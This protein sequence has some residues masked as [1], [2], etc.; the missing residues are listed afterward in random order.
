MFGPGPS[1]I[2]RVF[3]L[4]FTAFLA[5][6]CIAQTG[7]T[8]PATGGPS[9]FPNVDAGDRL[10]TLTPYAQITGVYDLTN[11]LTTTNQDGQLTKYDSTRIM[12]TGGL[13]GF[14]AWETSMLGMSFRGSF[15]H[16][17]KSN[18]P[19]SNSEFLSLG[20]QHAIS[21]HVTV[22]LTEIG[23]SSNLALSTAAFGL[24]GSSVLP[25][26]D[27]VD[28]ATSSLPINDLFDGRVYFSSTGSAVSYQRT[29][30]LSFFAGGGGFFVRRHETGAPGV[31]GATA[32]GGTMYQ[33]SRRQALSLEY[34][35]VR[36]DYT[37]RFGNADSQ[38][39]GLGYRATL[40]PHW[41]FQ[42]MAGAY[43]IRRLQ[44]TQV[45]LDPLV[46][47]LLGQ[48]TS[49]Q[50]QEGKSYL[51]AGNARLDGKF[52]HSTVTLS[53][54]RTSSA[55]NNVF[56]ASRLDLASGSYT[57]SLQK[58]CSLMLATAYTRLSSLGGDY[59][60]LEQIAAISSLS[61]RVANPI[62]FTASFSKRRMLV[63]TGNSRPDST[64]AMIG[65]GF[66][67]NGVPLW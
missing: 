7:H 43:R 26:L 62:Y 30:R 38:M 49:S 12:A 57:Y 13:D 8:D 4:C 6:H 40:S 61:Y 11:T 50:V 45:A 58:R 44:T 20:F 28:Q 23:G 35:F 55:G 21:R 54:R 16:R 47:A 66:S 60:P 42:A 25:G 17:L 51:G 34:T 1:T 32:H 63:N 53:Y 52:R 19:D 65:V 48:R 46:A 5:S 36:Y 18:V 56:L 41:E 67:P 15:Q 27:S 9:L 33:V 39:A 64:L 22:S 10:A 24:S 29:A 2:Q 37:G 31:N 14:H 59:K 3:V